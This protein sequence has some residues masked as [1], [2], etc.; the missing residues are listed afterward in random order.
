MALPTF[1]AAGTPASGIGDVSPAWPTH[2]AGDT[3]LLIV[4]STG[5][6]AAAL[7][8]PA[9]FVEVGNSPSAT[10]TTTLGTRLTV[11]YC[12]ATS[13]SMSAP[14]VTDPGNHAYAV[15]I[16][17][18]GGYTGGY[19]FDVTAAQQKA[20]ASTS[21][22]ITGVTTTRPNCLVIG[23]VG[24]DNDAAGAAF[25]SWAD[26]SLA[27]VTERFDNGT[28]DGNGGGIGVVTGEKATAGATGTITATV[29]SSI[30]AYLTL[31]LR[32]EQTPPTVALN[33]PADA[34]STNDTT[35]DLTFT[36]T[37][38]EGNPATYQIQID[39]VNTFDSQTA[40]SNYALRQS[41]KVPS[42]GYASVID[43]VMDMDFLPDSLIVV[44]L[45]YNNDTTGTITSMVDGVNTYTKITDIDN[46]G[47]TQYQRWYAWGID[48]VSSPTVSAAV[49]L[50]SHDMAM[51]VREYTGVLATG[52]PLDKEV[53]T[54][55]A[56]GTTHASGNTATTAEARELIVAGVGL[57]ANATI[58]AGGLSN[59]I[60]QNSSD[61]YESVGAG[62]KLAT[63]TGAQSA[64]FT[65]S[66]A[67]L[68]AVA[69]HTFK[70]AP[71][72]TPIISKLSA[73]DTGFVDV[74][75]GSDTDPFDSGD[76]IKYTVQSALAAGTYY[77]RVRA[78]DPAGSNSWGAWSSVRSFTVNPAET[79]GTAP[80]LVGVSVQTVAATH[81]S[82]AAAQPV[83][84][85]FTLPAVTA[86][87]L[88]PETAA[89]APVNAS[90]TV[91]PVT[92]RHRQT[93][94]VAPVLVAVSV[95]T[96]TATRQSVRTAA[97]QPV[98]ASF[99]L[100]PVAANHT[101]TAAV[102][103]LNIAA[104][105]QS[106][107]AI[108]R[109]TAAVQPVLVAV[110]VQATTATHRSTAAVSPVLASFTLPSVTAAA[111]V[112]AAVQPL[113]IAVSVQTVAA[114]HRSTAQ[115]LPLQATVQVQP[116][117]ADYD[118]VL[119]GSVQ[120]IEISATLPSVSALSS[121]TAEIVPLSIVASLQA[122]TA[123]HRSSASVQP[124]VAQFAVQP[125]SA[126][127]RFT[128]AAMPLLF[129]LSIQATLATHRQTAQAQPVLVSFSVQ[130]TTG[131]A[132]LV[133]EVEPV[134][135]A[136]AVQAVVA[137]PHFIGQ[138]LPVFAQF[139]LP[140][141][142]ATHNQTAAVA[143]LA[144]LFTLPPVLAVNRA[145]AVV[146]ALGI[147]ATLPEVTAIRVV[148]G[149]IIGG[150]PIPIGQTDRSAAIGQ[151]PQGVE[152]SQKDKATILTIRR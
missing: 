119:S 121:G 34:G 91:N 111:L 138:V 103:P 149:G 3:A 99:N 38:A 115:V 32:E 31:A 36:G 1:Q 84:A 82:T 18:R 27:N 83:L 80:V 61:L 127:P 13:G 4:E 20:S 106:V 90:F 70:L 73:S 88:Q 85:A 29:T 2:Q 141:V 93:A 139:D 57:G 124:V 135:A 58:T 108:N 133:A 7:S 48:A 43:A 25:S 152:L 102:Q 9:G 64:S 92:A 89:V 144:A 5:G 22:S 54:L 8:V 37:D 120:P 107:T 129:T 96:V 28:T 104:S 118:A 117:T 53:E 109:A 97:V 125:V 33:S 47:D 134:L 26:A 65:S 74:T 16:T 122:V 35:P 101:H 10:G 87:Y 50:N 130:T 128:A 132:Y 68:G 147:V 46:T 24:R 114:R 12:K 23:I 56:S 75:D 15:I 60:S 62:D 44:D 67:T 112:V 11:F 66:V 151:R 19:P 136:L 98:L 79:A 40:L 69:V 51:I 137:A 94:N 52:D 113:N 21:V 14:T 143:A 95:Q 145:S 148:T 86:T 41:K 77:W 17:F 6:Q 123:T 59:V 42:V 49:S 116:T 140:A 71:A 76:Q 45:V 105:V 142:G 30:N 150:R 131:R 63:S 39:T 126:E 81:R 55:T 110:S 100:P 72:S 146:Q 78:S